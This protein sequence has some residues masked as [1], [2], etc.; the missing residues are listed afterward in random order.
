MPAVRELQVNGVV[1]LLQA[2]SDRPLL[3]VLRDDLGLTGTKFGCGEGQ[4]GACTV[5]LDGVPIRSCLTPVGTVGPQK[6]TTIEG[7][8]RNGELHALQQAFLDVDAMQC[9]YCTSGMLMTGVVLLAKNPHPTDDEIVR[10]MDGNICRC[11]V[12]PSILAAIKRAAGHLAV[13]V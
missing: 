4:C 6:V 5:H 10:F 13:P 3:S 1:H 12:Y 7:L 8:E 11:G 2:D 9:A